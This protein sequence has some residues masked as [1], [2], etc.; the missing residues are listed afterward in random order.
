MQKLLTIPFLLF[1]ASSLCVAEDYL[2][3]GAGHLSAGNYLKAV[4]SYELALKSKQDDAAAY[5]GLG[6]AYFGLG[7]L[8]IAYNVEMIAAAVSAFNQS[9]SF[10]IDAEVCYLLGLSYLALSDK[11]HAETAHACLKSSDSKLAEKLGVKLAAYIKPAKFDYSQQA[12]PAPSGLT[13]VVIE[14]NRVLVPVQLS[15]RGHSVSTSLL[16]D[17]GASVTA[18]SERLAAELGV[19][20]MDSNPALVTVAD[21]RTVGCRWFVADALVVGPRNLPQLRTAVLPGSMAGVDG[22]LGMDFL[23]TVRY[24]VDFNRKVIEWNSR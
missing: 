13:P 10:K 6:T 15:Y 22:L 1:M 20:P 24:H 14:E 2:D 4:R 21:G 11:E 7:D 3:Q 16:L 18:I 5:K 9:L 12:P 17:T 19:E 8:G 23:R